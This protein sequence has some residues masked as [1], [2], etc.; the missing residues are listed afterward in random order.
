MWPINV[1]HLS[2]LSSVTISEPADNEFLRYDSGTGTWINE[3]VA[4]GGDIEVGTG[5]FP[6]APNDGQ[7]YYDLDSE[8]VYMWSDD[9]AAWIQVGGAG[10]GGEI[11][12]DNLGDHLATEGLDMGTNAITNVGNVD[13]VDVSALKTSYDAHLHNGDDL[14]CDE[15]DATSNLT[16]LASLAI[17]RA[18]SNNLG[19]YTE[20]TTISNIPR[21]S[22]IGGNDFYI[23]NGSTWQNLHAD[24]FTLHSLPLPI[25]ESTTKILNITN[26]DGKLDHKS[27]PTEAYFIDKNNENEGMKL[28]AMVMH[29]TKTIQELEQRI[30]DLENN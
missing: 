19:D 8:A 12:G 16:F 26:K 14:E 28:G 21:M 6:V 13:G 22:I 29:L 20:L 10:I 17:R 3:A 11:E 18:P 5:A 24:N 25:E 27:L 1:S 4:S 30:K 7:H 23:I 9:A 2:E 15:I